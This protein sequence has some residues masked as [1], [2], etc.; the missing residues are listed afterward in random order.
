MEGSSV[1]FDLALIFVGAKA[2]GAVFRRMGQPGVIGE[3]LV[4]I[5]IGPH[6]LGLIEVGEATSTLAELGAILLLFAV[7]LDTP[8][9][10]LKAVG[11][12]SLAVG[13]G[14]IVLPFL[15]GAGLLTLLGNPGGEALFVGTA[16][17]ATSVGVTARVLHDLGVVGL[18]VS[19]M[20]LGAAV[21][22]DILGLLLLAV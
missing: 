22:D 2:G 4:G 15:A 14:G 19:R 16:M 3:L 18:P 17:V 5:A 13:V 6:A 10:E 1:L 11:G 12:R 8:P 7:G 9:S 20:I 21:V